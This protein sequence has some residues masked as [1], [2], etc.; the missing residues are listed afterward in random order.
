MLQKLWN[1]G[2]SVEAIN[3]GFATDQDCNTSGY[4][5]LIEGTGKIITGI[6]NQGRFDEDFYTYRNSNM[7]K[8]HI[9]EIAEVD[10]L[11]RDTGL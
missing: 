11:T 3:L 5:F 6:S 1:C 8:Y 7:I 10:I 9:N 2:F 4:K